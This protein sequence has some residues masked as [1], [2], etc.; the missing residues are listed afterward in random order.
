MS[1][2]RGPWYLFTGL[3]IGFIVGLMYATLLAPARMIDFPPDLL[4]EDDKA[5]YRNLIALAYQA[6]R[7]IGR[8]KARLVLLKDDD[9]IDALTMQAQQVLAAEGPESVSEA[10]AQ[11]AESLS[12]ENVPQEVETKPSEITE[13]PEEISL[14]SSS[15]IQP[16]QSV[17]TPTPEATFTVT[18]Q[19]TFTPYPTF[20]PVAALTMA[21][22]LQEEEKIC[23]ADLPAGLLQIQIE[24]EEGNPVPGARIN[25]IWDEGEEY[26][27]TGLYPQIGLGYADYQMSASKTYQLHVGE[28]GEMVDD[29]SIPT[30]KDGGGNYFSGGWKLKFKSL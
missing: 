12:N 22:T 23:D 29:L 7:D 2:K 25:I 6:N 18:L 10:L 19:A 21:F 3:F 4:S 15:T 20:T 28:G 17:R 27:Y 8:A 30:C 13:T 5:E 16:G 24:D 11:L 26:F 14:L 9:M 1:E